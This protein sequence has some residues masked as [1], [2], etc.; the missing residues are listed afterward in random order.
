MGKVI[1]FLVAVGI[2]VAFFVFND[3]YKERNVDGVA[4]EVQ[5]LTFFISGEEVVLENGVA[6]ARTAL[7]GESDTTVRYFGNEIEHDVD[8]DGVEDIVFLVAQEAGGSGTFFYAVAALKRDDGY[9][10][11]HAVYIG[12]RIAPQTTEK[13]EGRRVIVNYADRAPGEPMS[14]Q[15]SVGKSLVLLLNPETLQFGEVVQDFEG[16][17]IR[18]EFGRN[19]EMWKRYRNDD[20][21]ISFEYRT[22]P[23]GYILI[24]QD[25]NEPEDARVL[26]YVSLFNK[27]EYL[28]LIVSS[29][30]REGPPGISVLVFENPE[31]YTA[32]DWVTQNTMFSNVGLAISDIETTTFAGASAVRYMTDGLYVNDNIVADHGGRIYMISG[33]YAVEDSPVRE[34][35]IDM[36]QYFSLH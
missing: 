24:E 26:E 8:G 9:I 2:V 7:G 5:N 17:G 20:L 35:F 32:N 12:D 36:L 25:E 10:G 14:T 15:P 3:T 30:P 27:K 6:T 18:D 11:S 29:V 13:G 4:K 21:G 1:G 33:S 22:E 23:D 19:G 31:G 28:E 16:D 34:D